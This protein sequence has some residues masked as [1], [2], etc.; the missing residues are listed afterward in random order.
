MLKIRAPKNPSTLKPIT[1][2][3]HRIIITA[4]ITKRKSPKVI[5]V[6]GNVKITNIGFTNKFNNPKTTATIIDDLKPST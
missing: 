1:S 5:M 6:T 2:L 4:L 3:E